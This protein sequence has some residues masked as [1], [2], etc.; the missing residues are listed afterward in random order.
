M[1]KLKDEHANLG[2]I[3]KKRQRLE[4]EEKTR[5]TEG[6]IANILASIE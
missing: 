4:N 1:R 2:G 5:E 6:E 3:F